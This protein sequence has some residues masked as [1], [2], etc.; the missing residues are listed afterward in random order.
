MMIISFLNYQAD[1]FIEIVA[2]PAFKSRTPELRFLIND[3]VANTHLSRPTSDRNNIRVA[4]PKKIKWRHDGEIESTRVYSIDEDSSTYGDVVM[5]MRR[6]VT[7][8]LQHPLPGNHADEPF[9]DNEYFSNK[10]K[11]SFAPRDESFSRWVH[12]TFGTDSVP[13]KIES[14]KEALFQLAQFERPCLEEAL[15]RLEAE[16]TSPRNGVAEGLAK[17]RRQ[18]EIWRMFCDVTDIYGQISVRRA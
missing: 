3:E 8:V 7:H 13:G 18:M 17:K 5:P 14:K 9:E 16:G 11:T 1:E 15:R 12:T 10:D 6:F 2:G 4:A